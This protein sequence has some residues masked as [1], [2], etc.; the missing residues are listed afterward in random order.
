MT[1]VLI[2]PA[3]AENSSVCPCPTFPALPLGTRKAA[4]R[5][6][7]VNLWRL[8][9]EFTV[10][11]LCV[12]LRLAS[13]T[14]KFRAAALLRWNEIMPQRWEW[15]LKV[16]TSVVQKLLLPLWMHLHGLHC[17]WTHLHLS[18]PSDTT[19]G[20]HLTSAP[21]FSRVF[22]SLTETNTRQIHIWLSCPRSFF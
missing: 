21:N 15:G 22:I 6:K 18:N 1:Q 7:E 8:K 19:Q 9:T 12:S 16:F 20:H 5:K 17:R 11:C 3:F 4:Y 10:S 14:G 2:H 13:E